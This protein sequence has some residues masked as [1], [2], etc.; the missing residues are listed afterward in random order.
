MWAAG[1]SK[2]K[3]NIPSITI[4]WLRPMPRCSRPPEIFWVVNASAAI[5]IGWRG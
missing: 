1:R 4:W 2:D 5:V 3:P